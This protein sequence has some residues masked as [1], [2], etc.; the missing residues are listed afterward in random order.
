[1]C[2][3]W[4]QLNLPVLYNYWLLLSLIHWFLCGFTWVINKSCY[5][6][7]PYYACKQRHSRNLVWF[8]YL[9]YKSQNVQKVAN[10]NTAE[11]LAKQNMNGTVWNYVYGLNAYA[12]YHKKSFK[13]IHWELVEWDVFVQ[14][15]VAVQ[16]NNPILYQ[17]YIWFPVCCVMAV[18]HT[19]IQ[20]S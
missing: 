19:T 5:E 18:P 3:I 16:T 15:N 4:S 11:I 9:L 14:M 20:K 17:P 7:V 6:S 13:H 12:I 2:L 10:L 8:C 1:M